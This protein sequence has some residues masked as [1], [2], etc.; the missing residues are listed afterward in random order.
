LEK[1]TFRGTNRETL[2]SKNRHTN[3]QIS[4]QIDEQAKEK[5]KT[6]QAKRT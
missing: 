1:N 2:I 5:W 4:E 6:R 3:K